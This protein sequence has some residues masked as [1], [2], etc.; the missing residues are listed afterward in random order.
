L[1]LEDIDFD[2]E[3]KELDSP[4][5]LKACEELGILPK[6]LYHKDL[7][8]FIRDNPD[9]INLSREILSIRFN[10]IE[11]YRHR[12]ISEVKEKRKSIIKKMNDIQRKSKTNN[13]IINEDDIMENEINEIMKRGAKTLEKIRQ[14]QKNII[15]AQ[16]ESKIKKEMLKIKSDKKEIKIR[17]L[18]E[19]I[20]E[21][22][23]LKSMI[24]KQKLKEKEEIR[25]KTIEK[26]LREK[27]K[28][29]EERNRAE[30]KRVKYFQ[31]MQEKNQMDLIFRRTQNFQL[32]EK[33]KEKIL[34]KLKELDKKNKEREDKNLKREKEMEEHIKKERAERMLYNEKKEREYKEKIKKNKL[35]KMNNIEALRKLLDIKE[36]K[37][38]IRL[39]GLITKRHKNL[40]AQKIRYEQK[41]KSVGDSIRKSK[42]E[43]QKRNHRIL[44]HQLQIDF[45][46]SKME[47]KKNEKILERAKSQNYLFLNSLKQRENNIIQMQSKFNELYKI[48]L[49]KNE[50]LKEE[51]IEQMKYRT[52]KNEKDF[53]KYY[54][55]QHNLIRLNRI[56]NYKNKKKLEESTQ[57]EKKIVMHKIRKQDLIHKNLLLGNSIEKEKVKLMEEFNKALLK[58]QEINSDLIKK[59]FPDD[60]KFCDKIKQMTDEAYN[61]YNNEKLDDI[62]NNDITKKGIDIF[63]TQHKNPYNNDTKDE[64]TKINGIKQN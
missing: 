49:Y 56:N 42:D 55:I 36:E 25:Q 62:N 14:Q 35:E 11:K 12:L 46:V 54:G 17:E 40:Q 24:E 1:S 38:L 60:T 4:R 23:K 8:E 48:S 63:L 34:D 29:Y 28:K 3:K 16:I 37:T 6:E 47:K 31:E 53:I 19:K 30:E 61:S 22:K 18:N 5:S 2:C 64:K 43:I 27:E 51:K 57:K 39:S 33:K 50:K 9:M 15:E 52:I 10:N 26:N 59:L 44:E 41:L 21:T 58:N 45:N 7:Q 13:R 32:L 20:K